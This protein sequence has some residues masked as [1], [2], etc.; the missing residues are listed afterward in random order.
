MSNTDIKKNANN[1]ICPHCKINSRQNWLYTNV[2]NFDNTNSFDLVGNEYIERNSGSAIDGSGVECG[3]KPIN[4]IS[5]AM[6]DNCKKATI[7]IDDVRVYPEALCVDDPIEEMN[8]DI[9]KL[10]LEAARIVEYSP[11]GAGAILRLAL[12]TLIKELGYTGNI[13]DCIKK[14][15]QNGLDSK[16]QKAMDSIRVIGNNAVHPGEINLDETKENVL[17][18]FRL[19]NYI[20]KE[21]IVKP[22]EIDDLFSELPDGA[23]SAI[24]KRDNK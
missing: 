14:M 18:L 23:L 11:K 7:W 21:L 9:K 6:C 3:I 16:I 24:N 10:Y 4:I 5:I 15:V 19:L 12:Q 13:N 2:V 20:V 8:E 1:F 22:K 17:V